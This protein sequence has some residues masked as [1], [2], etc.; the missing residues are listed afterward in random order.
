MQNPEVISTVPNKFSSI[1]LMA[2]FI[3]RD[4]KPGFS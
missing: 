1:K 4:F 3:A 2:F